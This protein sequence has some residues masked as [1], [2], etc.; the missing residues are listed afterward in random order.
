M[1]IFSKSTD[2]QLADARTSREM[3]QSRLVTART[4]AAE[5]RV[6]AQKA[7][8]DD[9][10]DAV[11]DK[12]EAKLRT[13]EI[14]V[15]TLTAALAE[16]DRHIRQL[17]QAAREAA[18]KARC[19][20][21][22]KVVIQNIDRRTAA[23]AKVDSALEEYAAVEREASWCPDA[24]AGLR[25]C[26][27]ARTELAAHTSM[28]QTLLKATMAAYPPE[29]VLAKPLPPP[30]PM[31]QPA[32]TMHV[33][34]LKPIAWM[35]DGMVQIAA[36]GTDLDL[37]PA[38]AQRGIKLGAVC[39]ATDP[40]RKAIKQ[41]GSFK[42][43][44]PLRRN[45]IDLDLDM[46]PDNEAEPFREPV[47]RSVPPGTIDPRLTPVDRGPAIVMKVPRNEQVPASASRELPKDDSK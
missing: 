24:L 7:A 41:V 40:R 45:C 22:D 25:F 14:R 1:S 20:E 3:L 30:A 38:T 10:D 5:H 29:L 47:L 28:M 42:I 11:L 37:S 15:E 21:R 43:G 8:R 9:V 19:A 6:A 35:V 2:K 12:I 39:E 13:T 36:P 34:S 46:P 16:T 17:E 32:P 27:G 33:T 26:E 23:G 4:L 44:K 18:D 31:P